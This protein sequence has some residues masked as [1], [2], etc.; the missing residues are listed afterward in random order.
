MVLNQTVP[1]VDRSECNNDSNNS[2]LENISGFFFWH[3]LI[4]ENSDKRTD[5]SIQA[6]S[7]TVDG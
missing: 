7:L 6:S 4:R 5:T 1:I 3:S 2:C